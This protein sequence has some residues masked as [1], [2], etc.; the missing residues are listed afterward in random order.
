MPAM[1]PPTRALPR[2]AR[3][4]GTTILTLA[5][6]G[7]GGLALLARSRLQKASGSDPASAARFVGS[8]V[9]AGC[10]PVEHA[11]WSSSHHRHAMEPANAGSVLGDFGGAV[12]RY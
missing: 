1:S 12:F 10:H 5:I 3:R 7:A 6:A 4:R 9:C 2:S 11:A 8:Q